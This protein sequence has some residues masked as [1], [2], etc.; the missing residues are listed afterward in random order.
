[1]GQALR[2]TQ[3]LN[4]LG[5]ARAHQCP[6]P[7]SGHA[8]PLARIFHARP[9]HVQFKDRRFRTKLFGFDYNYLPQFFFVCFG[10]EDDIVFAVPLRAISIRSDRS[11]PFM[12]LLGSVH[13]FPKRVGW[14]RFDL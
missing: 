3:A 14:L 4:Y 8:H 10:E 1:M 5:I 12:D 13:E 7:E 9:S 6:I 11:C 2:H